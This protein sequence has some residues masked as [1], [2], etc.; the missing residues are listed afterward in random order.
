MSSQEIPSSLR[1]RAAQEALEWCGTPYQHQTSLKGEGTDCLGL[2]RGIYRALYAREP[3]QPPPYARYA[4]PLE[5]EL[6]RDAARQFLYETK[7]DIA[8]GQVLLFQ[9]R[10]GFPARHIGIAISETHMVHALSG[11]HVCATSLTPW[12]QR[13]CVGQFTFPD[14]IVTKDE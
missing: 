4:K 13:H 3:Q 1:Q 2:L 14:L 8:M 10:R 5:A 11:A 12:W 6:L 9:L 7:G